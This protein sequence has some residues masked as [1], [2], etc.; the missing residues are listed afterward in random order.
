[1][2]FRAMG[3]DS[4]LV[5]IKSPCLASRL[6]GECAKDPPGRERS[7]GPWN[8]NRSVSGE[9]CLTQNLGTGRSV[10]CSSLK[11]LDRRPPLPDRRREVSMGLA[12]IEQPIQVAR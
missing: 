8:R 11:Q 6:N 4:L 9:K 12:A 1:M 5:V 10:P 2:I 3:V 7:Q